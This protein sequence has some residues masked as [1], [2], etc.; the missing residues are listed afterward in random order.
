LI[1]PRGHAPYAPTNNQLAVAVRSSE[2]NTYPNA[3]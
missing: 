3:A 1:D 2:N